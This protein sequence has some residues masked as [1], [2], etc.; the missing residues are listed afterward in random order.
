M[1]RPTWHQIRRQ[2]NQ[3]KKVKGVY[4]SELS[5]NGSVRVRRS[6]VVDD[7]GLPRVSASGPDLD[8]DAGRRAVLT[9]SPALVAPTTASVI[10]PFWRWWSCTVRCATLGTSVPGGRRAF[11]FGASP[12]QLAPR[13]RT[14]LQVSRSRF[15]YIDHHS[16]ILSLEFNFALQN[17]LPAAGRPYRLFALPCNDA[18]VGTS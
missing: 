7:D 11:R 4:Q 12:L 8:V 2:P 15:A 18:G 16:L 13:A 14:A 10:P 9:G 3:T 6:C 1:L 17:H 5:E